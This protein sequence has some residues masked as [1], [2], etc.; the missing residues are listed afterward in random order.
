MRDAA[1]RRTTGGQVLG[2]G[3]RLT[4]PEALALYTTGAAYAAHRDR[5]LGS[6]RPGKLADFTVLDGNPLTTAPERLTDVKVLATAVGGRPVCQD[7]ELLPP[8]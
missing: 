3:E 4:V 7:P 8:G 6:L 5:E 1:L 2:E